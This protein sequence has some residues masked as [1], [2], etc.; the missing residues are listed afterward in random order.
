ERYRE[1]ARGVA[2]F[3]RRHVPSLD[4][5]EHVD[6]GGGFPA[7]GRKPYARRAWDPRPVVES[8]AA[9][10]AG[11]APAFPGRRPRLILEPGR[12]L[13]GDAVVLVSRVIARR[14]APSRQVVLSNAS[15]TMLPATTYAPQEI[16]AFTEGLEERTSRTQET[17]VFGAS[18]RED[19]LLYRG[20]F[21]AVSTGDVLVHL[22]AGAYNASLAPEFIFERPRTIFW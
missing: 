7:D 15:V 12:Y 17:T 13:V 8:V 14:S 9:I 16:L 10:V 3:L 21:P 20:P 4:A 11:L 6:M 2:D 22:C 19:D 1:A 18:C 5:L